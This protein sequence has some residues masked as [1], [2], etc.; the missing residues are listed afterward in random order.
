MSEVVIIGAGISGLACA[1][2]L[3]KLG[4]DVEILEATSRA[5]GVIRTENISGYQIEWGPNSIQPAPAALKLIDE[6]G[7]WDDL[8]P[9][10]PHAPRYIY[11]NRRLRKF[12][13]GPLNFKGIARILAEPLVRSKSPRDESVRDF[14]ARR[15]GK[16]AHDRLAGP[17]FTGIY[18]TDTTQLS[19]AAVLPR[20]LEMERNY[21]SL[22]AAM[23][24]SLARRA[25]TAAPTKR[26][27]RGFTLSFPRGIETL[28]IR[29]A[30]N[31]TIRYGET[32]ARLAVASA[33]VL[34][35]PA[36]RAAGM[37]EKQYPDLAK[38][39]DK[40]RYSP[41]IVA[42]SSLPAHRLKE[43]LRG[44]G[45]LVPRSEGLHLLGTIFSSALFPGRA[46]EDQA[47][48]TSFIG[49]S[50]EPEV[51]RWPDERVWEV[52][53]SELQTV[54]NSDEKPQPVAL[55]RH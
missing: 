22:T 49:G 20:M 32:G 44:F 26:R 51:L 47:L 29:L 5:G 14:I 54:L 37:M 53:N 52:V 17:L 12:P 7:L 30:E 34:T 21:G 15:F 13:F 1:W 11:V 25:A 35:I 8:L 4:I 18:A 19:V 41:I 55:V 28:P 46:P 16:Q 10:D 40:V 9:P 43:P 33:T 31:L 24:R 42:A 6:V 23:V 39:L 2:T 36:Y 38:L 50:F 27:P 48:L 45:F 3:K